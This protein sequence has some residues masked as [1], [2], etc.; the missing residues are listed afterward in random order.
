MHFL[1]QSSHIRCGR[2]KE[3]GS[4]RR[5]AVVEGLV[6]AD[7]VYSVL[8]PQV[9]ENG[10]KKKKNA[11]DVIFPYYWRRQRMEIVEIVRAKPLHRIVNQASVRP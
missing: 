7:V 1:H 3:E 8:Y 4:H 6:K 2:H 10:F 5:K 11:V 9:H